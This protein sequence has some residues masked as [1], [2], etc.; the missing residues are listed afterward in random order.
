MEVPRGQ[1]PGRFAAKSVVQHG[2]QMRC[3]VPLVTLTTFGHPA[4]F[5]QC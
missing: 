1:Y 4:E 3:M 2:K 5:T